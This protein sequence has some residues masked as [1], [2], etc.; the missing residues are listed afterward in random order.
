MARSL[1]DE[2]KALVERYFEAIASGDFDLLES[3]MMPGL[4]F[5]C[6]GGTGAE[7]SVVFHSPGELRRDLEHTF[8]DLFDPDV[9]LQP[10]ILWI[11]AE[12]DR[13]AA[14]VRI[15]GRSAR[16]G[17]S[18]DNLYAFFFWI[19][20]GRFREIHEHLDTSYVERVVLRPAGIGSGAEM[21]WL[22]ERH[23]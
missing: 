6:A 16:S 5:R 10:E 22:G 9:G 7:D 11:L 23:E 17:E 8:G 18:Y 21:P 3:L 4:L 14:E 19:E 12:A 13:V 15:C 1:E 20:E 2:N